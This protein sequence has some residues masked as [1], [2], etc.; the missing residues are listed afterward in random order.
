MHR[1]PV[2]AVALAL[3]LV[4]AGC[5][6]ILGSGSPTATP[7]D[8]DLATADLCTG[9][10]NCALTDATALLAAHERELVATGF[11][12][13]VQVNATIIEQ[14]RVVNSQR[15]QRTVVEPG[16]R[17]YQYRTTNSPGGGTIQF[18][19]WAN[20]SVSVVRGQFGDTVRYQ[21]REPRSARTLT[22]RP[23]LD[24][25]LTGPD[26]EVVG[27]NESGGRT[28]VTLRSTEL[29]TDRNAVPSNATN[30]REYEARMV[31]DTQGRVH[32]FVASGTY[33][34]RGETYDFRLAYELVRTDE[35]SVSQPDWA[36]EALRNAG[37]GS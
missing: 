15:R 31:V 26:V 3:L 6:G 29:P 22:G 21:I 12:S 27:V 37:S 9:V 14:D 23:V 28:L 33:D 24:N 10:S 4:T 2:A 18:D 5:N 25:Y 16:F 17:E 13:D 34:L 36:A 11:E 19:H 8:Q 7:N 30:V 32:A 1:S 20:E 35:P